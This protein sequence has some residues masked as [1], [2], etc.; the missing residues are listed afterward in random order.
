[1]A[2]AKRAEE[3]VSQLVNEGIFLKL[4]KKISDVT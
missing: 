3:Q 4:F 2:W 1:M